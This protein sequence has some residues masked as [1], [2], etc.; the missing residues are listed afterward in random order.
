VRARAPAAL[1]AAGA[2]AASAPALPAQAAAS[3]LAASGGI[4][5]ATPLLVDGNGT[6]VRVAPAPWLGARVA[7]SR[8][9][10]GR[11][12][13]AAEARVGGSTLRL[14]APD[15]RW[16]GGTVWQGDLVL[17]ADVALT[18][19]VTAGAGVGVTWLAG[20]RDVAP[21]D[22]LRRPRAAAEAGVSV[23]P[24]GWPLAVNV[25]VQG[26]RVRPAGGAGGGVARL[27]AGVTYAP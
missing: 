17:R 24:R 6:T 4:A 9:R 5:I 22:R 15:A 25:A 10:T 19:R 13:L 7:P 12:A 26:F 2:L 18:P 14:R 3:R 20:P 16:R 8:L 11:L 21:L 27:L 23:R 1:L